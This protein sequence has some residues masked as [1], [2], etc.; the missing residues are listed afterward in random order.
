[1]Q[2]AFAGPISVFSLGLEMGWTSEIGQEGTRTLSLREAGPD[3][4]NP[5]GPHDDKAMSR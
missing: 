2:G 4:S 1:M 5:Y 3:R